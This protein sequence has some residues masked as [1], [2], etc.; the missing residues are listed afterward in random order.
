MSGAHPMQPLQVDENGIV[1]FKANRVVR[2]LLDHGGLDMNA[3]AEAAHTIKDGHGNPLFTQEDREQFAQLIGYSLGGYHELSYVSDESAK[4]ASDTAKGLGSEYG[5]C[6]DHGCAIHTQQVT[7]DT[8]SE[9]S[10]AIKRAIEDVKKGPTILGPYT[11]VNGETSDG[12]HTFNELYDH[13]ITLFLALAAEVESR[14]AKG[15]V[16]KSLKHFDGS[17]F[18]GW[19]IMGIGVDSGEQITYHLPMSRWD[20]AAFAMERTRAPLFDGHTPADVLQRLRKFF[21]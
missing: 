5:G 19:F 12:Y 2:F 3:L 10:D 4:A 13:R 14:T 18:D 6:R 11:V 7:G 20:D 9:D 21:T 15:Y 16:W 1:R 8:V 17:M